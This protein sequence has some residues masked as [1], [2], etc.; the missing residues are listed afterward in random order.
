MSKA[1]QYWRQK[2]AEKVA[3][4]GGYSRSR[5]AAFPLE[6]TVYCSPSL[7][8]AD[9]KPLLVEYGHF[10][11]EADI[12][13]QHP[14]FDEWF[15]HTYSDYALM[16]FA[17]EQVV[18]GLSSDEGMC[19]WSPET[20]KKYGFDYK[21][22]GAERGFECSFG[23]YGRGGKHVCVE[24]FEGVDFSEMSNDR[25]LEIINDMSQPGGTLDQSFSN[26]WVRQLC[27]MLDEWAQVFTTAN[28]EANAIYYATDRV[29]NDLN[30]LEDEREYA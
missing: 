29:A 18:E 7:D 28:A 16:Q 1:T 3:C 2:L 6:F 24:R 26:R 10:I 19:M 11:N 14:D 20:A 13:L 30:E 17:Q 8:A 25:M 9:I 27:G 23:N 21:G 22:D 5:E 12:E 15:R 4:I